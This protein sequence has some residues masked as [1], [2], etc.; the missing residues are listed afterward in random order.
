MIVT[1]PDPKTIDT[2]S[3]SEES[4]AAGIKKLKAKEKVTQNFGE[5][6]EEVSTAESDAV[7]GWDDNASLNDEDPW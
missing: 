2:D 6:K 1:Y 5:N 7:N 3:F 4:M